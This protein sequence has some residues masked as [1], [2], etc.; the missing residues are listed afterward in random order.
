MAKSIYD[1]ELHEPT[2]KGVYTIIRVPGGWIYQRT[3]V[4]AGGKIPSMVFVP[5]SDEFNAPA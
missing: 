5:Y 4:V 2:I 3:D 1:L